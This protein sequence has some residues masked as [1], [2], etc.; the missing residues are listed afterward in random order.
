M[1]VVNELWLWFDPGVL[2]NQPPERGSSSGRRMSFALVQRFSGTLGAVA[3]YLVPTPLN[4]Y[5]PSNFYC[6]RI[7]SWIYLDLFLQILLVS[8]YFCY[9]R[10]LLTKFILA[11]CFKS[12]TAFLTA[13]TAYLMDSYSKDPLIAAKW[14]KHHHARASMAVNSLQTSDIWNELNLNIEQLA[15]ET[16]NDII[17]KGPISQN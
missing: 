15:F 6:F 11:S 9:L 1:T 7:P 16:T 2:R 13:R 8:L 3:L 12:A 10:S 5:L 14:L 17:E 4:P